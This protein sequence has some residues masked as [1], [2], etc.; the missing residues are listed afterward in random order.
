[1][2]FKRVRAVRF[3]E[4]EHRKASDDLR[5]VMGVLRGLGGSLRSRYGK[6]H[7]LTKLREMANTTTRQADSRGMIV[8]G[9]ATAPLPPS[10]TGCSALTTPGPSEKGYGF[11]WKST[12]PEPNGESAPSYRRPRS[13]ASM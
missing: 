1:M 5:R 6:G 2:A 11:P 13:V 7:R 8:T 4:P 12:C 9:N 3:S 10:S